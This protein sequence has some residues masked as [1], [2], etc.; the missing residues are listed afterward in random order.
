[1]ADAALFS[2]RPSIAFTLSITDHSIGK[3]VSWR[4]D[5]DGNPLLPTEQR[6][7]LKSPLALLQAAARFAALARPSSGNKRWREEPP[8][9]LRYM[10]SEYLPAVRARVMFGC[11]ATVCKRWA[12]A[13][14]RLNVCARTKMRWV[15]CVMDRVM[16]GY[17]DA[18]QVQPQRRV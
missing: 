7:L 11:V 13:R 10:L 1:M 3:R 14:R 8:L 15:D 18:L 4:L 6:A 17:V 9:P 5:A 2:P 16:W 12:S